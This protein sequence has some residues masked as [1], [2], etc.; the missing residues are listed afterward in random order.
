MG[1]KGVKLGEAQIS[2]KHANFFINLACA[3]SKDMHSL[4]DMVKSMAKSKGL[5]LQEE[6]IFI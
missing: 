6:V 1:L 4:I 5:Y 2:N 3:S